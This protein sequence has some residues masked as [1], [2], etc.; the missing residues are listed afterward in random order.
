[1]RQT[2][3]ASITAAAMWMLIV[4]AGPTATAQ[5][6]GDYDLTWNTIDSGGGTSSG[7]E[8]SISGTIGQAEAAAL[9]AA[10]G[11]F[12]LIGGFWSG[13]ALPACTEYA[14]AD[15]DRDCDVDLDD[16]AFFVLC[17]AGPE[18]S[19]PPGCAEKNLDGDADIDQDDFAV[20]QRCFSGAGH[21]ADPTCAD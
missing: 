11:N 14:P 12:V 16:L 8:Y 4:W 18:M 2:H 21:P 13:M 7:G 17:A 5:V 9:P 10:G 3:T 20:F 15:F 19:I 1:M 6:G